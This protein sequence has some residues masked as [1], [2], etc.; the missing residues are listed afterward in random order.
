VADNVLLG[1]ISTDPYSPVDIY[2]PWLSRHGGMASFRDVQDMY[3]QNITV[4]LKVSVIYAN[5]GA[6]A[7]IA[8][9]TYVTSVELTQGS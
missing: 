4:R 2:L 5:C 3:P 7:I 6:I 1:G 8:S 9:M